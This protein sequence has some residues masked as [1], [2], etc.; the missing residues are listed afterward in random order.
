[1]LE[2]KPK[3]NNKPLSI[4]YSY[5]IPNLRN[6]ANKSLQFSATDLV[7]AEASWCTPGWWGSGG[8]N[9]A[10]RKAR[11]STGPR[12]VRTSAQGFY[13]GLAAHDT[14]LCWCRLCTRS[15]NM[16]HWSLCHHP[17]VGP[18]PLAPQLSLWHMAS[19]LWNASDLASNTISITNYGAQ[20]E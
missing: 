12:A 2:E 14:L 17:Q 8:E 1:M 6:A 19:G 13:S 10:M 16:E 15:R 18:Q 7:H 9:R 20:W 4:Y 11:P 5:R 3:H